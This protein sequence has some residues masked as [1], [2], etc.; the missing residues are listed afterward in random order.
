MNLQV[1][2]NVHAGI[3]DSGT[4]EVYFCV[5]GRCDEWSEKLGND[6]SRIKDGMKEGWFGPFVGP[7]SKLS[8]IFDLFKPTKITNHFPYFS[9]FRVIYDKDVVNMMA[10][11][12]AYGIKTGLE[13]L[14]FDAKSLS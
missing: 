1:T 8:L 14:G 4:V 5:N 6:V 12:C 7:E 11:N 9:T 10:H 3:Y 2:P 13:R